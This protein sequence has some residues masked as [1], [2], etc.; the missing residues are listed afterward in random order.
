MKEVRQISED[1]L[2]VLI[3]DFRETACDAETMLAFVIDEISFIQ[4]EALEMTNIQLQRICGEPGIPFGGVLLLL[5]GEFKQKAP[6]SRSPSPRK[7]R[8][9]G[10]SCI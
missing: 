1:E 6:L 8:R 9:S 5:A 3:A 7:G 2:T 10:S 4:P